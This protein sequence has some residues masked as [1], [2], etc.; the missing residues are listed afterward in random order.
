MSD[1]FIMQPWQ[2]SCLPLIY[3]HTKPLPVSWAASRTASASLNL[4]AHTHSP[5]LRQ[6]SFKHCIPEVIGILIHNHHLRL[7]GA[8]LVCQHPSSQQGGGD[9]G[10]LCLYQEQDLELDPGTVDLSQLVALENTLRRVPTLEH[11]QKTTLFPCRGDGGCSWL[12][13]S[14]A[15][16]PFHPLQALLPV[17][18]LAGCSQNFP[19]PL[20]YF[21]SN[22]VL[23]CRR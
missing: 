7:A 23:S 21:Y 3:Y 5:A 4:Q 22:A 2:P 13:I 15:A 16:S 18:R 6:K 9:L 12:E 17:P 19:L 8:A 11:T 20:V 10:A 14:P 1:G